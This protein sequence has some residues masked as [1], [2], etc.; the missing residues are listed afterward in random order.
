M[1]VFIALVSCLLSAIS[2]S[3]LVKNEVARCKN[4][5]MKK[6][7]NNADKLFYLSLTFLNESALPISI[8]NLRLYESGDYSST[9][10]SE[11]YSDGFLT[12]DSANV[13][14]TNRISRKYEIDYD[15]LS[16]T[17][18][19]VIEPYSAFGGYFAFHEG[20]D[21]SFIIGNKDVERFVTT[22]RKTYKIEMDLGSGNF[23]DISYQDNG[24]MFGL[25]VGGKRHQDT[26][27]P[28]NYR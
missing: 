16:I 7:S 4:E 12:I 15:A 20:G 19:F 28:D 27:I 13:A 26:S 14:S 9:H 11:G 6:I 21:D 25:A 23:Y 1:N 10:L 18:P 2:V 3:I 17:T 24:D 22:S 8:L 5:K